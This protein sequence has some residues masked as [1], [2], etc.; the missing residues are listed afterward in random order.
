MPVPKDLPPDLMKVMGAFM[1]IKWLMP[2]IA[3]AEIV[4]GILVITNRFRALGAI[5]LFPVIIGIV[6]THIMYAPSGLPIALIL[7]VVDLWIIFENWHKYT[8]MISHRDPKVR[9]N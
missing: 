5:I 7:L 8:P 1:E 2:L 3:I 6:L 4:G 9:M